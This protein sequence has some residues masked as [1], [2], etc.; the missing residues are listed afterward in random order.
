MKILETVTT[1]KD[2]YKMTLKVV[3]Y[4]STDEIGLQ[5][6]IADPT[7]DITIALDRV[8]MERILL[9]MKDHLLGEQ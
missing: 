8:D 3:E 5:V 7:Q 4:E 6:S 9:L 1:A 2:Y